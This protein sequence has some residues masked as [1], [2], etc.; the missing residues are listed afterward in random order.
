MIH[1]VAQMYVCNIFKAKFLD[2]WEES[3]DKSWGFT[4]PHFTKQYAKENCKLARN[5][6]NK[7]YESSA[8]F[9]ETPRSHSI[10][11]PYDRLTTTTADD[12]FAASMEYSAAL[13]EKTHTQAEHILEIE[14]SVDGQTILTEATDYA[15][16]AV[17]AEGNKKDLKGLR[18][19]M[20]QLT[21][22]VAVQ[23]ATLVALY[24][25]IH[26][27][28]SGGGG[29]GRKNTKMKKAQPGLHVCVHYKRDVY[30]KD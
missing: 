1:F 2:D 12:S 21:D 9:Q 17:T 7:S 15:A 28:G 13:E 16:I 20:K 11:T 4:Q 30:Q 3:G 6:S 22:S 8:A 27:G 24:V 19:M 29:G 26:S 25:K 23:A 18:A 5:K 10:E 14:A